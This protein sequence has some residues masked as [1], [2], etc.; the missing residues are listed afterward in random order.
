MKFVHFEIFYSK[1]C[2]I[3]VTKMDILSKYTL[4]L[5]FSVDSLHKKQFLIFTV[6]ILNVYCSKIEQN[7]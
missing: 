1:K 4:Y 2:L 7:E 3:C 6:Q 5:V